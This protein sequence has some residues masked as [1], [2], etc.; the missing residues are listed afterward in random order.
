[1][2]LC[3]K[4]DKNQMWKNYGRDNFATVLDEVVLCMLIIVLCLLNIKQPDM[5]FYFKDKA[6]V[7]SR[8][9]PSRKSLFSLEE[10]PPPPTGL[11]GRAG[12]QAPAENDF[13]EKK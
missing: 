1:M 3:P 2:R 10:S 4:T 5:D 12:I 9:R 11:L 13:L 7:H 6:T 8:W